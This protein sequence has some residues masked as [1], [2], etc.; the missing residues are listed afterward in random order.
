M[1][2]ALRFAV[3]HLLAIKPITMKAIFQ[4]TRCKEEDCLDVLRKIGK[5]SSPAADEWQLTEKAYKELDVWNFS[6]PSQELRQS[7]IDNAVRVFDRLRI[8]PE[9]QQWQMLLPKHERGKGIT[10]SKL[11]LNPQPNKPIRKMTPITKPT[12][13][14]APPKKANK[15][16]TAE[17]GKKNLT[18]DEEDEL[19]DEGRQALIDVQEQ[20]SPED[21]ISPTNTNVDKELPGQECEGGHR[22]SGS[23]ENDKSMVEESTV[24]TAKKTPLDGHKAGKTAG[25]GKKLNVEENLSV[26]D[27][28]NVTKKTG[29]AVRDKDAKAKK[30]TTPAN[31]KSNTSTTSPKLA[32][33]KAEKQSAEDQRAKSDTK[34]KTYSQNSPRGKPTSNAEPVKKPAVTTSS[35]PI[36]APWQPRKDRPVIRKGPK[37]PTSRSSQTPTEKNTVNNN[38]SQE[39]DSTRRLSTKP[40]IPSPLGAEPMVNTA[41]SSPLPV[42]PATQPA[43]NSAGNS[44]AGLK[45]KANDLDAKEDSDS[46]SEGT[47]HKHRKTNPSTSSLSSL[48]SQTTS[49]SVR[50]P[51]A[52]TSTIGARNGEKLLKRKSATCTADD[53]S[54]SPSKQRR[55]DSKSST[56]M[57]VRT[58]AVSARGGNANNKSEASVKPSS[59]LKP[60]PKPAPKI[61]SSTST[62]SGTKHSRSVTAKTDSKSDVTSDEQRMTK[63]AENTKVRHS[64]SNS[65]STVSSAASD[66]NSSN[67][68]SV[69]ATAPALTSASTSASNS[70]IDEAKGGATSPLQMSFRQTVEHARKFQKYYIP[71]AELYERL[72]SSPDPPSEKDR[73]TLMDMHDKLSVMKME[74][75]SGAL[76]QA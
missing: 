23:N 34:E 31:L 4:R 54:K 62:S 18:S 22:M 12:K 40:K 16:L 7:V 50:Q 38:V 60:L 58:E 5:Q 48:S 72:S 26:T 41:P 39:K 30:P 24:G 14:P 51:N 11:K 27:E 46:R 3:L 73:A 35:K 63:T 67:I 32:A 6:Y 75:R 2:K 64:P 70:D 25:Q 37:N 56:P 15:N 36:T 42:K 66:S 52:D 9:D 76:R 47:V 43:R 33:K 45:R 19:L 69:S 17:E 20:G 49:S 65:T 29:M 44:D 71:Y 10:L 57:K 13:K 74:I 53:T 1:Q 59:G 8:S 55:V 61:S 21:K 68:T 28:K